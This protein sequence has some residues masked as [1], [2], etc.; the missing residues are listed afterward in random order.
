MSA[1]FS[2]SASSDPRGCGPAATAGDWLD[3]LAACSGETDCVDFAPSPQ[4]LPPSS[5]HPTDCCNDDKDQDEGEQEK[6]QQQDEQHEDEEN[7]EGEEDKKEAD[8][9]LDV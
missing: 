3:W 2:T 6:V 8:N 9:E 1:L 4:P 7:D 5:P